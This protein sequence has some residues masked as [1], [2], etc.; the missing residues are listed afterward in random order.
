MTARRN[1]HIILAYVD[2]VIALW[3]FLSVDEPSSIESR[4]TAIPSN[5]DVPLSQAITCHHP[6]DREVRDTIV[7]L[8]EQDQF[9]KNYRPKQ[10]MSKLCRRKISEILIPS[11]IQI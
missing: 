3:L 6:M 2:A 10:I 5:H 1:T 7:Q 8:L 9:T 4:E 11:R